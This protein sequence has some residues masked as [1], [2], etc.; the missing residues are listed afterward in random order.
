[1]LLLQQIS[2]APL[3]RQMQEIIH[4][5]NHK[6]LQQLRTLIRVSL[7]LLLYIYLHVWNKIC[8]CFEVLEWFPPCLDP[9]LST[10]VSIIDQ[11]PCDTNTI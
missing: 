10:A 11:P 6:T 7:S 4:A 9:A 8:Q 2:T 5:I 1:M 3:S